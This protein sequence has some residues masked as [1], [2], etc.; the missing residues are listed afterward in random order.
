MEVGGYNR[1]PDWIKI[2]PSLLVAA[3]LVLAIRTSKLAKQDCGTT[4]T[5]EWDAEVER[6]TKIAHRVLSSLLANSP[7]LFAQRTCLG[8]SRQTKT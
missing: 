5:P 6:S 7:C 8:I 3:S 2:G 4:S 1:E